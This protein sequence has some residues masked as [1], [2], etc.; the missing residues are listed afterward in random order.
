VP[1][2]QDGP[3]AGFRERQSVVDEL[4]QF[5]QHSV[6]CYVL[7]WNR[8]QDLVVD[9]HGLHLVQEGHRLTIHDRAGLQCLI[10][11]EVAIHAASI[12]GAGADD[13]S[14]RIGICSSHAPRLPVLERALVIEQLVA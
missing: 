2:A 1:R 10:G 7:T 11:E 4:P 3:D 14:I 5:L 6:W 9:L 8:C 13:E 12:P